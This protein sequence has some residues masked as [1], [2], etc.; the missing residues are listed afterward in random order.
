[1]SI[2]DG[3]RYIL[4]DAWTS[5]DEKTTELVFVTEPVWTALTA[6]RAGDVRLADE[7]M[8]RQLDMIELK[9]NLRR[10]PTIQ[11]RELISAMWLHAH[12]T[13]ADVPRWSVILF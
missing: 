6:Y 2:H 8:T 5:T 4:L 10:V 7:A 1:M 11:D 9:L 12:A 3:R 13:Q